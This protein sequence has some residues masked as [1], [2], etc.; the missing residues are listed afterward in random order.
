MLYFDTRTAALA[1]DQVVAP[2]F[3]SRTAPRGL[4]N[5]AW[6][7]CFTYV[8]TYTLPKTGAAENS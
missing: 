4:N 6:C 3:T 7:M 8:S 2:V 5:S 1:P